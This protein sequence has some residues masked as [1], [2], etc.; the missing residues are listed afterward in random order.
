MKAKNYHNEE[1]NFSIG[2]TVTLVE[3]CG[4]MS[5][6]KIGGFFQ[7]MLELISP[8]GKSQGWELPQNCF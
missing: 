7:R 4:T 5:Q 6:M 8:D 1:V 2:N 3:D